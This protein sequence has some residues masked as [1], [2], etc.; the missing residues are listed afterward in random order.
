MDSGIQSRA[1]CT[2]IMP[3]VLEIHVAGRRAYLTNEDHGELKM[4]RRQAKGVR[5]ALKIWLKLYR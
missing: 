4:T 1:L 2:G 3:K 5:K